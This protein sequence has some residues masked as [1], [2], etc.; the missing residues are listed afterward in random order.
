M[1][2]K[3]AITDNEIFIVYKLL[4]RV[5]MLP[6]GEKKTKKNRWLFLTLKAT[7]Y[8]FKICRCDQINSL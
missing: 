3:L 2:A 6:W 7:C 8:K 4:E 5:G 1:L